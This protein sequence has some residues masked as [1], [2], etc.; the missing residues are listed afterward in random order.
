VTCLPEN[1][2]AFAATLPPNL[3][4]PNWRNG[5]LGSSCTDVKM[6]VAAAI[7]EPT[8]AFLIG[9]TWLSLGGELSSSWLE[10]D[11]GVATSLLLPVLAAG[12]VVV[13]A[14]GVLPE[15]AAALRIGNDVV[16]AGTLSHIS[17]ALAWNMAACCKMERE[18][19][20]V[21][22][23]GSFGGCCCCCGC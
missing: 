10:L 4:G 8:G 20:V 12:A 15:G 3:R 22:L 11:T 14:A 6:L 16:R 1:S 13:M 19:L 2:A 5:G 9:R 18:A 7:A 23:V 21:A 17:T